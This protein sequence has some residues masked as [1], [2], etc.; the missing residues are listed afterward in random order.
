MIINLIVYKY[1]NA[2]HRTIK[3]KTTDTKRSTSI[4]F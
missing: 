2:Y 4:D 3:P 1:S